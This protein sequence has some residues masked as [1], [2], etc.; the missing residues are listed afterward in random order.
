MPNSKPSDAKLR[1]IVE[2]YQ[3]LTGKPLIPLVPSDADELRVM[4]WDAPRAVVAHGTEADPIFFYGNRLALQW[5]E[6][7]AEEFAQ[8]PSRLSAEPMAQQARVDLL[9]KVMRHGY[10][11]GYAG[12]RIAKS[13]KRFMISDATVWNLLDEMGGFHGQAAVFVSGA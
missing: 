12:I 6:M 2:S 3:R 10:V 9:E 11:D 1:L 5:F 4:L 13:G 7:T 8:L